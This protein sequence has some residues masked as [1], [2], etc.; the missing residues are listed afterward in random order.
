MRGL[1]NQ[2]RSSMCA[3][4]PTSARSTSW[5]GSPLLTPG[6]SF[7]GMVM[8]VARPFFSALLVVI[9]SFPLNT[10]HAEALALHDPTASLEAQVSPV[11]NWASPC[12]PPTSVNGPKVP[13]TAPAGSR[14]GASSSTSS[15]VLPRRPW[16]FGC[17]KASGGLL[18][19]LHS[20]TVS[21]CAPP[22][23]SVSFATHSGYS[24]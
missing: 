8:L 24:R 19:A 12:S 15:R 21:A 17:W 1:M 13:T 16:T 9:S 2:T 18:F 22:N 23:H 6:M 14:L 11:K 10:T 7:R 5:K 20:S 4:S 3:A